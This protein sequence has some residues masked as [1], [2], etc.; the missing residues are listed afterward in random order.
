MKSL[1]KL[2]KNPCFYAAA[3]FFGLSIYEAIK[4]DK[5]RQA[6]KG[7]DILHKADIAA[8]KLDKKHLEYQLAEAKGDVIAKLEA[9]HEGIDALKN[10][11][12]CE[13]E[14]IKVTHESGVYSKVKEDVDKLQKNLDFNE[15]ALN[16]AKDG[17]LFAE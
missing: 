4:V 2:F 6:I 12:S 16:K 5:C 10:L 1:V 15:R 9:K 8:H 13:R 14:A 17:S 7:L 11:I 3:Y